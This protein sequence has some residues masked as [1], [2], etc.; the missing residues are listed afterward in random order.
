MGFSWDWLSGFQ[1]NF[2]QFQ[3]TS[4]QIGS[5][6]AMPS[7]VLSSQVR[8]SQASTEKQLADSDKPTEGQE[9]EARMG[10]FQQF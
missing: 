2:S 5:A 8:S 1:F 7:H 6:A 9:A 4:G 10:G 3:V